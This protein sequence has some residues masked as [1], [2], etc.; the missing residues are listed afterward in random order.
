MRLARFAVAI[1]VAGF[2]FSAVDKADAQICLPTFGYGNVGYS[3][4][5][6]I[7][8]VGWCGPRFGG[9]CGPRWGEQHPHACH[10]NSTLESLL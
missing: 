4:G 7:Q 10:A 9:W 8:Q 3:A 5:Y 1:L 6:S 2:M